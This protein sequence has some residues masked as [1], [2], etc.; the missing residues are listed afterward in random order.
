L[1]GEVPEAL[2]P[3]IGGLVYG[4]DICQD[5]CPWNVKFAQ[6]LRETACTPRA[7]IAE[8]DARSLARELIAM[9]DES[10]R[11][12]FKGSPMKRAKLRGLKRNAAVVL[13]NVGNQAD[14]PVLKSAMEDADALVREHATR[15][16][17]AVT[18]ECAR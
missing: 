6:E 16:L 10:F 14:V 17:A 3:A 11:S 7:A 4:C 5:V 15:A 8:R 12:A 13:G 9:D 1:K 2:Q 18:R